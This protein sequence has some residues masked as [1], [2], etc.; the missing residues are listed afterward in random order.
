MCIVD[1][2]DG[3]DLR[4]ATHDKAVEVI[5]NSRSPVT[6]LVQS[7]VVDDWV[8]HQ[9]ALVYVRMMIVE[10]CSTVKEKYF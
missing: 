10:I 1:Q 4:E 9:N 7:L 5:K 8:S 6:F 2:V 3:V